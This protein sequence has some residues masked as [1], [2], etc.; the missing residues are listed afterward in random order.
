MKVRI[1]LSL[2]VGLLA[3]WFSV[4]SA[5]EAGGARP[6]FVLKQ[7]PEAKRGKRSPSL[8]SASRDEIDGSSCEDDVRVLVTDF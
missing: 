4:N 1:F 8:R 7:T 5:V 2:T 6:L 3:G